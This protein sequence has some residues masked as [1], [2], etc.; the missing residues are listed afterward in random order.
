MSII[1]LTKQAQKIVDSDVPQNGGVGAPEITDQMIEAGL[2]VL[3]ASGLVDGPSGEDTPLV[4]EIY[5]AMHR[6]RPSR[7]QT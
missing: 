2:E 3:Y 1:T 6:R 7:F 4:V 5:C